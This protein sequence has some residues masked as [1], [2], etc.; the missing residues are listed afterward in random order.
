MMGFRSKHPA[1][2]AWEKGELA[3][4]LELSRDLPAE[5]GLRLRFLIAATTGQYHEALTAHAA[6]SRS[7]RAR[8]DVDHAYVAVRSHLERFETCLSET[9]VVPFA[10]HPLTPYFPA[11]DVE[12][13]GCALVAHLDTGGPFLVMNPERACTIGIELT[14]AEAGYHGSRKTRRFAG[15][16]RSLRLGAAA[17][18]NVPVECL[19]TLSGEQD[20]VIV[21][22]RLLEQFLATIDYAGKQLV[23]SPRGP[24]FRDAHYRRLA[25]AERVEVPF[26]LWGDHYLWAR[27]GVSDHRD[28]N[29]FVDS[30]LVLLKPDGRGG[31]KQAALSAQTR[32]FRDWG[33]PR[34]DTR[35]KLFDAPL[36]L[37]LGEVSAENFM[38]HVD[39]R[40]AWSSF[41]GVRIDGLISHA[42]LSRR[43]WTLDFDRRLFV[44]SGS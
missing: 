34:G 2:R 44:F 23:L 13:N 32:S 31:Q 30:G 40:P 25:E 17:L 12:I 9:T 26:F 18:Q 11:F 7:S 41:G 21:G 43:A 20:F 24:A 10:D 42:F 5:E 39:D 37:S 16:A 1:W 33:V 8:R 22:T 4:A 15:R 19:S 29:F 27:G 28:L 6:L 38:F 36:R 3:T 14:P 35:G